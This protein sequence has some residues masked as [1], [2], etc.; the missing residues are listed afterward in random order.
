M[1]RLDP[2][3]E[4]RRTRDGSSARWEL[5]S[6]EVFERDDHTCQRCGYD[7][8]D[9]DG[10]D[11]GRRL[12]AHHITTHGSPSFEQLDDLVTVCEPCHATLHSDDPAYDDARARAPM[13]PRPDAPPA[14]STMR[15]DRQH[16]CQRCQY[17][18]E[19]ATE[20]AAYTHDNRPYVLCKPCAGALLEAGFDP[21]A[22]EVAGDTGVDSLRSRASE[23]PVRPA[24]LASRPVRVTRPPETRFERV[25]YDTPLRYVLNPFGL[26]ALF[27]LV[28]VVFSFYVF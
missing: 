6:K 18:A 26:T 9:G 14:V 21:N 3:V 13:F 28:G 17:V 19:S 8:T 12:Q 4:R 25:V 1:S 11:E 20:L 10:G 27:I 24:L 7:T 16:V 23:A 15:N 22:F 5:L 2:R